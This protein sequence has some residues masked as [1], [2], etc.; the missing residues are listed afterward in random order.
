MLHIISMQCIYVD[1]YLYYLSIVYYNNN[2]NSVKIYFN[3]ELI[4]LGM[5]LW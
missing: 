4:K 2:Y 3:S 1:L 5:L